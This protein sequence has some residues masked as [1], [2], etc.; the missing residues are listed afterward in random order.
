MD[1]NK[2]RQTRSLVADL[3]TRAKDDGEKVIEGY[4]A[5]FNSETELWPG[6]YE[7]IAP[8]AFNNTLNNDIRALMNH[9]TAFVL[10]RTKSNTLTLKVDEHGLWGS[11]KI[12]E[13][14][15]DA[16]NLYQRVK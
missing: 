4:F 7:E 11:I 8:E 6:A 12:N 15:T 10:G 1:R 5:V 13:N 14:D 2:T 3:Q 9:D 16:M